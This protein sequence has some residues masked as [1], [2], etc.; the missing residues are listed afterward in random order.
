MKTHFLFPNQFKTIGW[1]LFIPSFIAGAFLLFSDFDFDRNYEI[2]VFA[3]LND[4]ILSD[5]KYCTIIKYGILDE[6]LVISIITGAVFIGFSKTKNE[7]EF[8]SKI[9]YESLV[10]ATYLNLGLM[11]LST[12]FIYVFSYFNVLIINIFS[13]L[14]FFIIRFHFMIF[15]LNK[16][17]SDDE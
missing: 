5:I 10:W 2:Q 12:L 17:F 6:L 14:I 7:D 15:K 1:I 9:R 3:F 4:A 11:I 8:I 13:M 16:S